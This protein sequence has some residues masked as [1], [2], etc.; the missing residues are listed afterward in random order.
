MSIEL[1]LAF[2]AVH[3]AASLAPG[4]AVLLVSSIGLARGFLPGVAASLGILTGNTIYFC[5]SIAGVGAILATSALLFTLVKWT[6]AAYLVWMGIQSWRQARRMAEQGPPEPLSAARDSYVQGVVKQLA[7]PKSVL[8]FG[9]LVPQFITPGET[10]PVHYL[11]MLAG[12]HLTEL[13][14]LAGYA[15]LG[16]RGGQLVRSPAGIV[17]RERLAGTAQIAVGGFLATLRRSG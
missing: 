13:P 6:G 3:I 14:I 7:N 2:L 9:A 10:G 5:V 12:M 17:W 15:W 16:T 11:A 4:P 1:F 8:F